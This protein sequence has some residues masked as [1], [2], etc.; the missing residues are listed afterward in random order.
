MPPSE[1]RNG[2]DWSL[3]SQDVLRNPNPE[4]TKKTLSISMDISQIRLHRSSKSDEYATSNRFVYPA[5]TFNFARPARVSRTTKKLSKIVRD[6][7][8][9]S[10]WL[11]CVW[12]GSYKQR[13]SGRTPLRSVCEPVLANGYKR[14][15]YL[16]TVAKARPIEAQSAPTPSRDLN[17]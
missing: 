10:F 14:C 2:G 16:Q 7:P 6:V 3:G 5:M 12:W 17:K 8:L 15:E 13:P 9:A 11:L 4:K 1:Q